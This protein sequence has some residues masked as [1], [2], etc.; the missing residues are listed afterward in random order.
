LKMGMRYS[1]SPLSPGDK[2]KVQEVMIYDK[3]NYC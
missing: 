1:L 3:N 2:H